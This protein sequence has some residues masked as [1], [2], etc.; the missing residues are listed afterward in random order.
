MTLVKDPHGGGG[1]SDGGARHR[2]GLSGAVLFTIGGLIVALEGLTIPGR[3]AA[4]M[5]SVFVIGL[6]AVVLGVG[7]LFV[8]WRRLPRRVQ[9][10][11]AIPALGFIGMGNWLDPNPYLAVVFFFVVSMWVGIAQ[12]RGTTL[13]LSPL[14]AVAY[15]WPIEIVPHVAGLRQSVPYVV[16]P[17]VL[18]GET[19]G[20]LMARLN[21]AQRRL[22]EHDERR[23]QALLA[24]SSDT[25]V[26]LGPAHDVSYVSASAGR[27]L[28]L[29]AGELT[30]LTVAA[31]IGQSVHPE[32]ASLLS[33]QLDELFAT[34]G[35]EKVVRFRVAGPAGT[36]NEVEGFG[37]NMLAD[38]TVE[39]V[40]FNLRDVSERASLERELTQ[41]A[42]TDR[43]TGLPNRAL[44]R[45][46]IQTAMQVAGR[47]GH[48]V[49]LLLID[50]DRFKEVNDTL[51]H[52]YGDQLLQEI[53]RR[54]ELSVRGSD[55]V[56]RL[57]GD[58]F[59]ILLPEVTS[60]EDAI[61]GVDRLRATIEAEFLVSGLSM[62]VDAS[63]GL[64]VYPGHA[65]DPDELLQCAEIAMYAA[66][67]AHLDHAIYD[68]ELN[69]HSPRRLSLL[70]QMRRAL[71]NREFVVHYQPKADSQS[72]RVIGVEALVRWQ[73]PDYGLIGPD[74]FIVLAEATGLIRPLT[75]YVLESALRER[76]RWLADGH[77]LSV[78]VNVSARCLLDLKFPFDVAAMLSDSGAP[79]ERLVLEITESAIMNDPPR[80]LEVLNQL[81][82]MNIRLSI[83]DFGTGYS[84]MAYLKDLPVDELKVDRSFVTHMREQLKGHTIVRSTIDLAHNLGLKVVAEGVEDEETWQ[85]LDVLG[86][87]TIQGYYLARPMTTRD[88]TTWLDTRPQPVD[89]K[90]PSPSPTAGQRVH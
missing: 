21:A 48:T 1:G 56:A 13:V 87:D 9:L 86:C 55:T 47:N 81:H 54:F 61:A 68:A 90:Q 3:S 5:W 42:F 44:L 39:G 17:C 24:A 20:W 62:D 35:A 51:G 50:L 77:D 7:Y 40:L 27:V 29:S 34:H 43:L 49:A 73:H 28:Q 70:G 18:A 25:T 89:Q 6:L 76:Q 78:A 67:T 12:P 2:S 31:F 38:D 11:I 58:E 33:A 83:D 88:L 14:F 15:W 84:S 19:M 72:R 10:V 23:F 41:Q 85:A 22:R 30:G 16:L 79:S 69:R 45:D 26:V 46:R 37:R 8:P 80:A 36:W 65:A 75:S 66:K 63:I 53:A 32:D 52:H 60:I 59:A 71:T 4:V 82:A 57:G 64:A 74:E